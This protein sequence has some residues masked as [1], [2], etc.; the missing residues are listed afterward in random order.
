MVIHERQSFPDELT[1]GD[2]GAADEFFGGMVIAAIEQT[3]GLSEAGP[4]IAVT[5]LSESLMEAL[6]RDHGVFNGDDLILELILKG[7]D[8]GGYDPLDSFGCEGSII[9]DEAIGED[10][11]IEHTL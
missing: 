11:E 8:H 10:I 7:R 5:I 2:G 9:G 1:D 6:L 4:I 3:I